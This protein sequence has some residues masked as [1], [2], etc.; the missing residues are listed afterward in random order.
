V[1]EL[2]KLIGEK[3]EYLVARLLETIGWDGFQTGETVP[4]VHPKVHKLKASI[5]ERRDHGIDI[6]HTFRSNLQDFTL[7]QVVLS[8]K[9][10]KD[11]Y[12][13][14]PVNT[15]K[16]HLEGLAHDVQCFSRSPMRVENIQQ[17]EM[18]GVE[19][20]TD[21][22]VLF[23]LNNSRESDQDVVS[24]IKNINLDKSLS[25]KDIY[26]VDN[27]RAAFIYDTIEFIQNRFDNYTHFFHYAFSSTNYLDSQIDKYGRVM[28]VEY[29][30]ADILP[31]RL[32]D[33]S[34]KKISFCISSRDEFSEES[35]MR[36][37]SMASDVSQEFTSEVILLFPDYDS[38]EHEKSLAKAIRTRD[39][40]LPKINIRAFAYIS[41]F[42]GMINE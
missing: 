10:S 34:S 12:P 2:S 18:K 25:F 15:F 16:T 23:W 9:Y 28:P 38:L 32:V 41:D 20:A 14:S 21:I 24:K 5:G 8:V 42:R 17:Y 26:I 30:A 27:S 39:D 3:G 6:F 35:A 19:N 36:L 13:K 37:L 1:G 31:F 22:G 33:N 40:D 29:F 4:C 11:P 7:E